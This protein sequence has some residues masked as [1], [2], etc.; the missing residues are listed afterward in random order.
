MKRKAL[1]Q[2]VI[3]RRENNT[4]KVAIFD[5]RECV[6]SEAHPKDEAVK[7]VLKSMKRLGV[8]EGL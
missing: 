6:D 8:M 3:T 2:I 5:G 7:L 4:F 1:S